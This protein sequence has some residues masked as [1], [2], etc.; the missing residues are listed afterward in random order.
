MPADRHGFVQRSP[1]VL[2][3]ALSARSGRLPWWP[4][5]EARSVPVTPERP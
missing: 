5:F 3:I 2:L 1:L 4:S